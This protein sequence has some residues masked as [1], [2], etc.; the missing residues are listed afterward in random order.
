MTFQFCTQGQKTYQPSKP[1]SEMEDVPFWSLIFSHTQ[2]VPCDRLR[3]LSLVNGYLLTSI[4][5]LWISSNIVSHSH[6]SHTLLP[7]SMSSIL[8]GHPSNKSKQA[9]SNCAYSSSVSPSCYVLWILSTVLVDF[10]KTRLS[11]PLIICASAPC[12][13]LQKCNLFMLHPSLGCLKTSHPLFRSKVPMGLSRCSTRKTSRSRRSQAS[14]D[15]L[16]HRLLRSRCAPSLLSSCR[17]R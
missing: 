2:I 15:R 17:S 12:L 8:S 5:T 11:Q 14:I 9:E 1:H 6:P 13:V 10:W 16:T 4:L 3:G 7:L